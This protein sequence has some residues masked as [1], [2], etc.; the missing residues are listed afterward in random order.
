M[1]T[2]LFVIIF[3]LQEYHEEHALQ[4]FR[5]FDKGNSGFISLKDMKKILVNMCP[6]LLSEHVET[7]LPMVSTILLSIRFT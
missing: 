4:A 5:K 3:G 6:H 2:K 7:S 1:C